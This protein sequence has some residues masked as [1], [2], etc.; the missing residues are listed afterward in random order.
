MGILLLNIFTNKLLHFLFKIKDRVMDALSTVVALDR[1]VSYFSQNQNSR[2]SPPVDSKVANASQQLSR[3]RKH[4][5]QSV[6]EGVRL[7]SREPKHL[8]KEVGESG[9]SD[10]KEKDK[11]LDEMQ[12][13]MIEYQKLTFL[14]VSSFLSGKT[15]GI[16]SD[17]NKLNGKVENLERENKKHQKEQTSTVDQLTAE[18]AILKHRLSK[19]ELVSNKKTVDD[20]NRLE[21]KQLHIKL[22]KAEDRISIL[23]KQI[24]EMHSGMGHMQSLLMSTFQIAMQA[25]SASTTSSF[26][27]MNMPFN[28]SGGFNLPPLMP[29]SISGM[30]NSFTQAPPDPGLLKILESFFAP[31]NQGVVKKADQ[32]ATKK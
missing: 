12:A 8:N 3:K 23:E 10:T 22:K 21:I 13:T 27:P 6:G 18:N 1:N 25:R 14:S 11:S 28:G 32:D 31:K 16:I 20:V 5:D 26:N 30:P 4:D 17:I 9:E 24:T 15:E 7:S 19:L 2:K 29:S